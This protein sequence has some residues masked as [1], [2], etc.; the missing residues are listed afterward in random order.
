MKLKKT[1]MDNTNFLSLSFKIRNRKYM[2]A[3]G[4]SYE[5]W[6]RGSPE[7]KKFF[8]IEKHVGK[9]TTTYGIYIG[10]LGLCLMV[11]RLDKGGLK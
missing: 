1:V 3:S 5:W 10:K 8:D 2:L 7:N 6:Y 9:E 11:E 4:W